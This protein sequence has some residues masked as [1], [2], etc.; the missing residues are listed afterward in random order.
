MDPRP[1][2]VGASLAIS[3]ISQRSPGDSCIRLG[4]LALAIIPYCCH[5]H[6]HNHHLPNCF[7]WVKNISMPHHTLEC[8]CM[9]QS[10]HIIFESNL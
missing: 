9:Q 8:L 6:Y 10:R 7:H 5:H 2:R 4:Q 3:T 1:P